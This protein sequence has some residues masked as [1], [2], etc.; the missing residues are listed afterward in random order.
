[1]RE[2]WPSHPYEDGPTLSSLLTPVTKALLIV[3]TTVSIA[4]WLLSRF[5]PI[6]LELFF[7]L[8]WPGLMTGHFWQLVTYIFLHYDPMHLLMNMIGLFFFGPELERTLGQIRFLCYYLLFGLI[9]G[10]FWI[11]I[12]ARMGDLC[13]GASGSIFGLL[14]LFAALFPARRIL[15]FLPLPI[16]VT[17]RTMALILGTMTLLYL[18]LFSRNIADAAHL[19]GGLAGYL[20]GLHLHRLGVHWGAQL[21]PWWRDWQIRRRQRRMHVLHPDSDAHDTPSEETINRILDKINRTGY[22]SLSR[23]EHEILEKASRTPRG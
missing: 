22:A 19:A 11:L 13:L 17:A 5:T 1:M 8:S 12:S 7:G 4:Q 10:L 9:G 16:S 2:T 21:V 14:G 6:H 15:L 23:A 18:L 3:T 20:Y